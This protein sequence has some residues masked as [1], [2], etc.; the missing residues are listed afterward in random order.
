VQNAGWAGR[1][2][3]ILDVWAPL[4]SSLVAIPFLAVL[5][6]G[7]I[8]LPQCLPPSLVVCVPMAAGCCGGGGLALLTLAVFHYCS[9]WCPGLHPCS[10]SW[11]VVAAHGLSL[12]SWS[13]WLWSLAP[14]PSLL[15]PAVA[16]PWFHFARPLL[17]L[18]SSC[19]HPPVIIPLS[20]S[21]CGHGHA[22]LH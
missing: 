11:V 5:V 22:P 9:P 21:H 13:S 14:P 15:S 16:V 1:H 18:F 19:H 10:C 17:G 12:L 7:I 8:G 4:L 6:V 3:V 2:I 20:L